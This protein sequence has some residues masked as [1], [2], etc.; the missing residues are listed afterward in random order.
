[1]QNSGFAPIYGMNNFSKIL[2]WARNFF[3]PAF[4]SLCETALLYAGEIKHG[5]CDNCR[6]SLEPAGGI[7]CVK[8]GKPLISEMEIC[9]PCRN[10]VHNYDRLFVIYPYTG[11][12]RKLLTAYKFKKRLSLSHLFVKEIIKKINDNP[13]LA[14]AVIVPVPPRPGKKKE[15]GWDQVDYLAGCLEKTKGFLPVNRCLRRRKS[16]AQKNLN[17]KDR[18][19]NMKDRIYCAG[20]IPQTVLVI[21]DVTTTGSTMEICVKTLKDAGAEH[22]YGLCLFYD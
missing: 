7:K 4:C 11:K 10:C 13:E 9:L 21:D 17:R 15:L 22:V 14:D 8:C 6:H 18:L 19:E 3:F 12:Y 5:L 16:K 1:M 20:H 2:F